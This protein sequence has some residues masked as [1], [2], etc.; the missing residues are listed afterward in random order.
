MALAQIPVSN[1]SVK[2]RFCVTNRQAQVACKT[3]NLKNASSAFRISAYPAST[4]TALLV[5]TVSGLPLIG[6]SLS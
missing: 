5:K 1:Q 2:M 3:G 6:D 4:L